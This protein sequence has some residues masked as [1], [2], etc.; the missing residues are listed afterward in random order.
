[1]I[2]DEPVNQRIT[3]L[4]DSGAEGMFIDE[5]LVQNW[6]KVKLKKPVKVRNIDGTE[7]SAGQITH[8]IFIPYSLYGEQLTDWFYVTN[9]GDQRMILGMPWLEEHNPIIDWVQKSLEL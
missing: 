9:L 7:N 6:N 1:M 3:A 8:R 5:T 4:V 2:F